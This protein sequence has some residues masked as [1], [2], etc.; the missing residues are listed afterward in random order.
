MK[1]EKDS[2]GKWGASLTTMQ[3]IKKAIKNGVPITAGIFPIRKIRG[4]KAEYIYKNFDMQT[5]Y[6]GKVLGW[7]LDLGMDK[8]GERGFDEKGTWLFSPSNTIYNDGIMFRH[9]EAPCKG[10]CKGD[11]IKLISAS[12][13]VITL[14]KR[15][16]VAKSMGIVRI[17]EMGLDGL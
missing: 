9:L 4:A 1:F 2:F 14:P 11:G 3:E 16:R 12:H 5:L 13:E 15:E 7:F 8:V 10:D 17:N 6:G